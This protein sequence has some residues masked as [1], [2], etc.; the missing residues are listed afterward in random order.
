MNANELKRKPATPLPWRAYDSCFGEFLIMDTDL[1]HSVSATFPSEEDRNYVLHVVD[2]YP[3]LIA[4][5]KGSISSHPPDCP[6]MIV[7]GI[8]ECGCGALHYNRQ[9]ESILRECGENE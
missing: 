3:K 1:R 6:R 4:F 8:E 7:N 5:I 2:S 9:V